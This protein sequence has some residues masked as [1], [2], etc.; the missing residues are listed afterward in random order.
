MTTS[1]SRSHFAVLLLLVAGASDA[2]AQQPPAPPP[3][4]DRPEY[5]QFDM[6]VGDWV[7]LNAAGDTVG[8]NRI[9]RISD[10][11]A[12]LEQWRDAGGGT[13]T[14]INFFEPETGRWNQLWVGGRGMVLRLEG[15]FSNGAMELAGTAPRATPQGA[16]LDRIR[17]TARQD[18]SVEQLWLIS[19]DDGSTWQES[20]RG[21][22]RRAGAA[23]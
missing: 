7:V 12:L 13:G 15:G 11:C 4:C 1:P 14:S 19:A 18:G 8:T 21:I 16:V 20:F 3:G 17:W 10:G 23:N 22:Y 5:R 6:W 9:E 2:A